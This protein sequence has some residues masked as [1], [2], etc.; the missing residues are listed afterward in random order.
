MSTY[1]S[2]L[3]AEKFPTDTHIATTTAAAAA[4]TDAAAA[5]AAANA[6]ASAAVANGVSSIPLALRERSGAVRRE[7]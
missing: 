3:N 2:P 6:A 4:N 1:L 5:A 7:R